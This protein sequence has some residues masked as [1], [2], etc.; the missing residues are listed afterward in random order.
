[1]GGSISNYEM[2]TNETFAKSTQMNQVFDYITSNPVNLNNI[3]KKVNDT[4]SYV[5]YNSR[6]TLFYQNENQTAEFFLPD[7]IVAIADGF[8]EV[9]VTFS[10]MRIGQGAVNGT[11]TAQGS[12]EEIAIGFRFNDKAAN[13][14]KYEIVDYLPFSCDNLK[15]TY[16]SGNNDSQ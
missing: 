11:G 14:T 10:W 13:F 4:I 15:L 8:V 2:W 1:M 5:I 7:K 3:T 12:S 9:K 6:T 16:I